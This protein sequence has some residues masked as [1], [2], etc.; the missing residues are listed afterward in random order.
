MSSLDPVDSAVASALER[1]GKFVSRHPR[2]IT[3]AVV[4]A[5]AGFGVT[6]FGIAPLA[7]DAADLPSRIVTETVTPEGITSQLEALAANELE[8]YRNDLTRASDTADTLLRRLNVDDPHAAAFIRGDAV[9]RKLV[10]GRAGKMVQVRT[11]A[12]GELDFLVAR[13]AAENSEQ[14]GT[15][16][17]RLRI[18]RV[19]GQFQAKVDTLPM[20]SQIRMGSGTIR[21]SLFAATDDAHIP[22]PV[23][24]QLAEI[25]ATDVDFHRELRRGDSFRV[26]YE[27]LTADGEPITWSQSSGRV[28]AAEFTNNGKT[29]SAVWFKD[30]ASG[31]GA[32]FDMN[33]QSKRRSFLASPLEFSRITSGFAMRM[34]PIQQTWKQHNG[35]DYGAPSGTPV[36]T[37]G[38]G[39]VEFAGW[40][41]GYGNVVSIKHSNNRSTVYA[42]LSRID[43]RRGQRVD[44][45]L[46]IGAVGAT[47]WATGPHL[48]F[49]VKLNGI[50]QNPLTIAKASE[51]LTISPAGKVQFTQ[52]A[53]GVR[54][55][56]D[57][58]Q[59]IAGSSMYA[60]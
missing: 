1:T 54:A 13:Y 40:Q 17:T 37:V 47:G 18:S 35:V 49:E 27:A 44:Q 8:L 20:A 55:Q 58:A 51:T 12:S 16:F 56:L 26:I 45:G 28:L 4:L 32:Y 30:P 38:D 14:A 5:L 29:F 48:H 3:T 41:N 9:A 23:A 50:H 39:T 34:H 10:S 25:F 24:N 42:H 60:E 57:A 21:N 46:R 22:D 53:Q 36:R 43:V 19:N 6:A 2:S 33:G 15:H 7:P 52:V 31:K 11:D 59:T